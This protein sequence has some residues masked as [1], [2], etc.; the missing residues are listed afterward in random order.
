MGSITVEIN[1]SFMER[2]TKT[3]TAMHGG[4][5]QAVAETIEWLAKDILPKAIQ[6]DHMLQSLGDKPEIGFGQ[7]GEEVM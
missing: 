7:K 4:H 5:A 1:G 3:F 2:P 6:Q